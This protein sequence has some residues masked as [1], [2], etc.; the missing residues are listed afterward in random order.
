MFSAQ[1]SI[2]EKAARL[3]MIDIPGT[4]MS[5]AVKQHL[6]EN[7]WNGVIL[8][9]KNVAD[10]AQT[11]RFIN[12]IHDNAALSPFIA[13]DQE[14]GLVDRLRFPDMSLAPGLMALGAAN[15]VEHTYEAHRIMGQE[16][17]QLGIHLDFAPC[18]D[19]NNNPLN[20]I[21]GVRSF[22]ADP[23]LVAR[24]GEAAIRG[25]RDGGVAPTAKHFPGHG[26]TAFDSHQALA[27]ISSSREAM[28][29]T[30]LVPFRA[31]V[32]AQVEAIMTAH[33]TFPALDPSNLPATLSK[34]LLTGLLREEL[35]YQGVIVTDSLAMKAVADHWGFAEATVLSVEAG[36]DL[37]LAL[38]SFER[39]LE[40][41]NGLVAAVESGRIS[42]ARLD[43]SLARLQA[44]YDR[45]HGRPESDPV[46]APAH[47]AAMQ[48][49][50]DQTVTILRDELSLIPFDSA[51]QPNL[52]IIA[53]DV[54]PQSPLGEVQPR[55]PMAEAFTQNG[56]T[57]SEM[58]Y[59]QSMNG[60]AIPELCHHAA[61]ADAVILAMYARGPLSDTQKRIYEEVLSHNAN[62]AVVALSSP[63]IVN[64]LPD[65]KCC[66]T[67]FG[68]GDL[69]ID[70]IAKVLTGQM[71]AQGQLPL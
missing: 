35:G 15:N 69:S 67:A 1:L 27:T 58:N 39:H 42:E 46:F 57:V 17:K 59:N 53:P 8:F 38:G 6:S 21:I 11:E 30:E 24:H 60:P 3:I 34:P 68:Y 19:V 52:L 4:E 49:I 64:E 41:L 45:Y 48:S 28:E 50:T 25:L 71:A 18:L 43:E 22:G 40:A 70:A 10:K 51:K 36:A 55:R 13:V 33:I 12:A 7:A 62:L 2:R 63:Y 31:A 20:P 5:D 23:Q 9:A 32:A 16:L 14:G 61:E 37:I 66:L 47:R 29:A 44:L 54:L 26:N 56:F 65:L